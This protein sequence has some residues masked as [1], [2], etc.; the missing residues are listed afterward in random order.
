METPALAAFLNQE[1][2]DHGSHGATLPTRIV[3]RSAVR[4]LRSLFITYAIEIEGDTPLYFYAE[5]VDD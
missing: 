4:G 1:T 2:A 5:G 3:L